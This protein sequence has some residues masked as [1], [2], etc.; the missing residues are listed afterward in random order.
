MLAVG[1]IGAPTRAMALDVGHATQG[2]HQQSAT[3]SGFSSEGWGLP[4]LHFSGLNDP[5]S[6]LADRGRCRVL[7]NYFAVLTLGLHATQLAD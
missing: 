1:V 3:R 4:S 5:P 6:R 7:L 2:R